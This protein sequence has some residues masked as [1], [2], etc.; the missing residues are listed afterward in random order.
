MAARPWG[1]PRLAISCCSDI[2]RI[3]PVRGRQRVAWTGRLGPVARR[4]VRRPSPRRARRGSITTRY[5]F[6]ASVVNRNAIRGRARRGVGRESA[7]DRAPNQSAR[8][9]RRSWVAASAGSR[10]CLRRRPIPPPA[11]HRIAARSLMPASPR[12][13]ARAKPSRGV[14]SKPGASSL[15]RIAEELARQPGPVAQRLVRRRARPEDGR[16]TSPRATGRHPACSITTQAAPD[17]WPARSERPSWP[18][19]ISPTGR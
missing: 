6:R 10:S 19:A 5:R 13:P 18:V 7:R 12:C 1:S 3:L 2:G 4:L 11:R 15:L 17:D 16:G 9:L 8:P 14:T